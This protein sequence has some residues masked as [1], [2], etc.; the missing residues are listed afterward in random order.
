MLRDLRHNAFKTCVWRFLVF[1]HVSYLQIL[2]I[3]KTNSCQGAA[4][5]T[6][7]RTSLRQIISDNLF[8]VVADCNYLFLSTF[9]VNY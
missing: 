1:G 8:L 3:S 2:A 7:L 5:S 6:P 4:H 9:L